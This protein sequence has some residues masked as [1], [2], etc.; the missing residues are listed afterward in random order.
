M[1]NSSQKNTEKVKIF[2]LRKKTANIKGKKVNNTR[3]TL[4]QNS[5]GHILN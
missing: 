1:K 5:Q 3:Q 2:H 4:L